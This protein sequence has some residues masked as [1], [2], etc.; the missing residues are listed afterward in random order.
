MNARAPGLF[1][2]NRA[3]TGANGKHHA[4]HVQ[5]FPHHRCALIRP[6]IARAV[7]FLPANQVYGGK[8]LGAVN[9]N[10]RIMFVILQKNVVTG[11]VPLDEIAFQNEGF[12]FSVHQHDVKIIH[13]FHHGLHLWRMTFGWMKVLPHPVFQ[14]FCL[15][16]IDNFAPGF[17]Q[18]TARRI[19]QGGD[20]QLKFFG[21]ACLLEENDVRLHQR[22][23]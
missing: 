21:H 6:E 22:T 18:I 10:E 14:I 8:R 5:H 19:R 9:A 23:Q 20:F 15:A 17:H 7:L 4:R 11:H 16:D 13:L 3:G 2:V 1:R 12:Q